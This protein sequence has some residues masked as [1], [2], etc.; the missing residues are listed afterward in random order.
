MSTV[1]LSVTA[2]LETSTVTAPSRPSR[3]TGIQVANL[4]HADR[5]APSRPHTVTFA[6]LF[7]GRIRDGGLD[8]VR[9]GRGIEKR[10]VSLT[11]PTLVGT[12]CAGMGSVQSAV[13]TA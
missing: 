1:T 10:S 5:H 13:Q 3:K 8:D 4:R 12:H 9:K 7:R 11:H 6:T 2:G